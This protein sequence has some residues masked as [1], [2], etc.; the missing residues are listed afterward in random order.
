MIKGDDEEAFIIP[1][2]DVVPRAG[3][4]ELSQRHSIV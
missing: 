1:F 4:T 2:V 3:T